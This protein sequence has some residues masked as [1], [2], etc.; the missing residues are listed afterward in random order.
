MSERCDGNL[1][2]REHVCVWVRQVVDNRD[3]STSKKEEI[4][5]LQQKSYVREMP[6]K[7]RFFVFPN[8][9]KNLK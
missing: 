3:S 1:G 9:K 2:V 5:I 6:E 8:S 4:L 7:F